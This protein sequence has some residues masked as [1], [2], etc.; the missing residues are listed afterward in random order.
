[1][2]HRASNKQFS[3]GAFSLQAWAA[4]TYVACKKDLW[5][6]KSE[7]ELVPLMAGPFACHERERTSKTEWF[8]NWKIGW[9]I[10]VVVLV[11]RWAVG[12]SLWSVGRQSSRGAEHTAGSWDRP[13]VR[14]ESVSVDLEAKSTVSRAPWDMS[15]SARGNGRLWSSRTLWWSR[16]WIRPCLVPA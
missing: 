15:T 6:N 8:L 16:K 3:R 4:H 7:T 12:L 11:N 14:F 10:F 13:R 9:K 1:M 5:T 2:R